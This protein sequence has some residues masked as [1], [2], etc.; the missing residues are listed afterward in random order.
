MLGA[1][2]A[3]ELGLPIRFLI[4]ASNENNI[5]TDF[6]RT[7]SYDLRNRIF[8]KTISPSID[9]LISSNLERF[10]YFTVLDKYF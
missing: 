4:T 9:I 1:I 8:K 3:R 6:I 5:I 7:G 10:L 2:F